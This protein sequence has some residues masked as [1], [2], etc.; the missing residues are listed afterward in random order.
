MEEDDNDDDDE[1]GDKQQQR[2]RIFLFCFAVL[3]TFLYIG[4]LFGWGPMQL[5]V[6]ILSKE[7]GSVRSVLYG[8]QLAAHSS[9]ILSSFNASA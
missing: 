5:L 6:R 4:A 1:D 7:V 9:S 8:L 3:Y 2:R